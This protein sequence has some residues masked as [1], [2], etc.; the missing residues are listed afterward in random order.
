MNAGFD[1]LCALYRR[2]H[3]LT[4]RHSTQ[5]TNEYPLSDY[6]EPQWSREWIRGVSLPAVAAWI[7][8]LCSLSEPAPKG[9]HSI[10]HEAV[11]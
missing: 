7:R 9:K 11:V 10:H 5:G 2:E 4:L 3:L 6:I 8:E 1:A